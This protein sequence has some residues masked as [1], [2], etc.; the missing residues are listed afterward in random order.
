MAGGWKTEWRAKDGSVNPGE[1][2]LMAE[3]LGSQ[4]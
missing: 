4:I 2:K 3:F 1:M